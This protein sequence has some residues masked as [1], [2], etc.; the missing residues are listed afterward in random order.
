[1]CKGGFLE[2]KEPEEEQRA[3]AALMKEVGVTLVLQGGTVG[4]SNG[5][6]EPYQPGVPQTGHAKTD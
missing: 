4:D 1:M 5:P 6:R 3:L 2:P